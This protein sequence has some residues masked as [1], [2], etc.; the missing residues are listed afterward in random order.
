MFRILEAT[1]VSLS[2]VVNSGL[3]DSNFFIFQISFFY[4][5]YFM[6]FLFTKSNFN[7]R[8]LLVSVP[9]I[10]L[11]G[12]YVHWTAKYSGTYR[13]TLGSQQTKTN[14][15]SKEQMFVCV[16]ICVFFLKVCSFA[17]LGL[18]EAGIDL[19]KLSVCSLC[20]LN[21]TKCLPGKRTHF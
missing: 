3:N 14:V 13:G 18:V 6:I 11:F 10:K 19:L 1:I 16:F 15:C 4:S 21:Q 2:A 9:W 20:N 7:S 12:Q 17:S 5:F 8:N